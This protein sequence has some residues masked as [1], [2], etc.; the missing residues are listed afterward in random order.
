M[1][2]LE[3]IEVKDNIMEMWNCP[4]DLIFVS[5]NVNTTG[6]TGGAGTAYPSAAFN[7]TLVLS[8]VRVALFLI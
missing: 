5:F 6:A 1:T 3:L 7:F 4:Y 2:G 8:G